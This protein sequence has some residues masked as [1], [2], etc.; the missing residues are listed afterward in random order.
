MK[1]VRTITNCI[2]NFEQVY[3]IDRE[4]GDGG[5]IYSYFYLNNG[6]KFDAIDTPDIF[7]LG[8]ESVE[9]EYEFCSLCHAE[10]NACIVEIINNYFEKHTALFSVQDYEEEI[11][12]NFDQWANKNKDELFKRRES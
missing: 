12:K 10:I 4:E 7:M 9:V 3:K 5:K 1:Y 11:W 6:E 2:I 8:S